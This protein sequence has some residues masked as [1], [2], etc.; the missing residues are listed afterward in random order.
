MHPLV[1]QQVQS[2]LCLLNRSETVT[3]FA[4]L[5]MSSVVVVSS[6]AVVDCTNMSLQL[7]LMVVAAARILTR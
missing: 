7:V 5:Q 6:I 4:T 2:A 3:L 1:L